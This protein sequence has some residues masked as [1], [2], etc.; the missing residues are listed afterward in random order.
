MEIDFTKKGMIIMSKEIN[1]KNMTSDDLDKLI[2]SAKAQ[3][4]I[5]KQRELQ[6]EAE[7]ERNKKIQ[8]AERILLQTGET[9]DSLLQKETI[10]L[11]GKN[12][13][14]EL[15][16][17]KTELSNIKRWMNEVSI[18][19]STGMTSNVYSLYERVFSTWLS[20]QK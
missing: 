15:E 11:D 13:S 9:L 19:T 3:K 16:K 4:K 17:L 8:L 12:D 14:E 10:C 20:L 5:V 7:I 1:M 6:K 18:T 2:K